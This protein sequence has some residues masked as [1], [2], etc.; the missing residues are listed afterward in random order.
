VIETDM[1]VH[2]LF[3]WERKIFLVENIIFAKEQ[4]RYYLSQ[5]KSKTY[6]RACHGLRLTK[7]VT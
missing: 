3:P 7:L 4:K 1:G 2:R 6:Y 5:K